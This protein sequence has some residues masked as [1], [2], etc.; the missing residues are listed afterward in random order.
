MP[1]LNPPRETCFKCFKPRSTCVCALIDPVD[2][3]TGVFVLQHPR[4]RAHPIGT[5]RFVELGLRRSRVD[6]AYSEGLKA[7]LKLPPRTGLLFPRPDARD[8][9]TLPEEDRPEHLLVLDGTWAHARSL[10]RQNPW[11]SE[12]P[13]YQLSPTAPSRYRIRR[14]P[15]PEYVSTLES[16]LLALRILE[17]ETRGFDGLLRAFDS[18]VD[19][20][21]EKA[22]EAG[23][24]GEP[25]RQKRVR[26][27]RV[28]RGVPRWLAEDSERLVALY[29]EALPSTAVRGETE[30]QGA[31]GEPDGAPRAL[32]QLVGMRVAT[33]ECFEFMF[34]P[35][36]G[37]PNAEALSSLELGT[38]AFDDAMPPVAL[39]AALKAFLKP[40]EVCIA[41]NGLTPSLMH[42]ATGVPHRVRLL[43]PV[44]RQ[45]GPLSEDGSLQSLDLLAEQA[46]QALTPLAMPDLSRVGELRGRAASRLRN[47][48]VV[49][50]WAR[51]RGRKDELL[52]DQLPKDPLPEDQPQCD[53][54]VATL[55]SA[56]LPMT[57]RRAQE[58]LLGAGLD[59]TYHF[60]G[61]SL[62]VN[63]P[64]GLLRVAL[65]DEQGAAL[66]LSGEPTLD[67]AL[68]L[69]RLLRRAWP[70]VGLARLDAEPGDGDGDGDA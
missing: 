48:C 9:E 35:V 58:E 52:K 17:P 68:D 41:W 47:L 65:L 14:E 10:Y 70:G 22:A 23:R 60:E 12:L 28:F 56:L 42:D 11:L 43:K 38:E 13:H 1:D 15:S 50:R 37:I 3:R 21:I 45:L 61:G 44:L 49:A 24:R 59:G 20:Q 57:L 64:A 63:L 5:A 36:S 62:F 69:E 34:R 53:R 25:K 2:N 39:A 7:R 66:E 67:P 32:L 30:A 46:E 55:P 19:T 54:L 31:E 8:L 27:E 33:G 40:G 29:A 51:E 4:E 18:M 16:V 26:R 6:V